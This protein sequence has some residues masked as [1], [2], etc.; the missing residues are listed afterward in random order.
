MHG[1]GAGREGYGCGEAYR[2]ALEVMAVVSPV[3]QRNSRTTNGPRAWSPAPRTKQPNKT[4]PTKTE[5]PKPS[6]PTHSKLKTEQP[7]TE[8]EPSQT[9]QNQSKP[10]RDRT[11]P[12]QTYAQISQIATADMWSYS[13]NRDRTEQTEQSKPSQSK[14]NRAKANQTELVSTNNDP[15][16]ASFAIFNDE[17]PLQFQFSNNHLS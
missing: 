10:N 8:T 3:G 1:T 6:N 14:P 11:K 9:E 16:A 2:R 5:Q 15:V 12:N 4:E 13:A 7:K 17:C